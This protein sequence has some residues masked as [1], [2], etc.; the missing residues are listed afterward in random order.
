MIWKSKW[1]SPK[2]ISKKETQRNFEEWNGCIVALGSFFIWGNTH[3]E[4]EEFI[5]FFKSSFLILYF[6]LIFENLLPTEEMVLV[7]EDIG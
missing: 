7:G 6:H 2:A 3:F 5:S 4:V 1:Y